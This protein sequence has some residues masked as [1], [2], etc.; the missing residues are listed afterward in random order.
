MDM[1]IG[2]DIVMDMGWILAPLGSL[3]G[4]KIDTF[5]DLWKLFFAA[6]YNVL[7]TLEGPRIIQKS[8]IFGNFV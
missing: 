8:M 6:M 2:M 3:L 5:G 7:A 1:D 4:S